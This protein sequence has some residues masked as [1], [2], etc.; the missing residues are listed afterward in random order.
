MTN[1]YV[2]TYASAFGDDPNPAVR[3]A[4]EAGCKAR[5]RRLRHRARPRSTASRPR[6]ARSRGSTNGATLAATMEKFKKVPTLSGLV[7]FSP[8]LHSVFGRQYRVI[9]IQNNKAQLRRRRRPPRS[10]RR[11]RALAEQSTH[12]N[13]AEARRTRSGPPRVSRV[14]RGRAGARRRHARAA[15]ARGRRPDRPERRRQVDARQRAHRLRLRRRRAASSSDE[16]GRDAV[17]PAP[18][19]PRRTRADVPAQPLVPRAHRARERRGRGARRRERGRGRRGAG[20]TS[21]SQR[22]GARRADATGRRRSPT[23]TSAGSASRARSR[24]SRA[25]VL[26][27]RARR[28]AC[29]RRRCPSSPRSSGRSATTTTRASC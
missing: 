28:P 18:A 21:C 29:R 14:L 6:S 11:S 12:A 5:H 15:P 4:R 26:H 22:L 19:R 16:R 8:Q 13:D 9:K 24:R 23:A 10:F 27:G 1:Y 17:E 20:P 7:S 25:F 2:V 3:R